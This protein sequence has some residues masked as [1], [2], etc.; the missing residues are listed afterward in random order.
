MRLASSNRWIFKKLAFTNCLDYTM[1]ADVCQLFFEK[2]REKNHPA[3]N[4]AE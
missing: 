3:G 1:S 4:P 2:I